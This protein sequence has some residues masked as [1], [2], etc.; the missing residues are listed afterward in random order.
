M[1]TLEMVKENLNVKTNMD[2]ANQYMGMIGALEHD[3]A[4]ADLTASLSSEIIHTLGYPRREVELAAIAGYLHDIGNLVH[5]Y[6]HGS[7]GAIIAFRL[8]KGMGMDPEE[9]TTIMGAI[10]NHEENAGGRAVNNVS[11]AVILADKSDVNNSRVRKDDS[12]KFTDRDRVNYAA[13]ESTLAIDA[14]DRLI[15]MNLIIDTEVCS[16]MDYFEIFLTKMM[17][18]KRAAEYLGCRFELTI[19][20]M[21]FL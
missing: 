20:D 21:K 2:M 5:R 17:M 1:I 19:N 4:H 3:A 7:S 10:A 14:M 18:C 15:S 8:L 9:V 6:R 12:S 11:A 13:Q 16:V